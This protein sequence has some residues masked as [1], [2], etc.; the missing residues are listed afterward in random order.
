MDLDYLAKNPGDS[1]CYDPSFRNSLESELP[2]LITNT[3][4]RPYSLTDQQLYEFQHDFYGL[5]LSI[6]I[7]PQYHYYIFRFN[8]FK[9]IEDFTT[10]TNTIMMPDLA[11]YDIMVEVYKT[12]TVAI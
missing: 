8:G 5:L 7:P 1:M 12:K 10:T 9:A 11:N 4:S 2:Y 6:N 3:P